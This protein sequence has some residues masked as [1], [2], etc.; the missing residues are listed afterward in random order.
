MRRGRDSNQGLDSLSVEENSPLSD[1]DDLAKS[2]DSD[3]KYAN[4]GDLETPPDDSRIDS[5]ALDLA[6]T[7]ALAKALDA[8][9]T[10]GLIDHARPIA[11]ELVLLLEA[12]QDIGAE[13]TSLGS[14]R[15]LRGK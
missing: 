6:R 11:K 3:D 2:A 1:L 5:V 14:A 4:A 13:V 9:V 10:G 12:A 15:S 8:F 7:I